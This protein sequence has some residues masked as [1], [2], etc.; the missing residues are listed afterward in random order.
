VGQEEA[1][2]LQ[3]TLG[4]LPDDYRRVL[5]L[6]FKEDRSFE[7]IGRLLSWTTNAARKVWTRVAQ[8]LQQET[9]GTS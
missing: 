7:E 3:E 6:P 4:R 9:E 1:C 5:R 2:R 8:R